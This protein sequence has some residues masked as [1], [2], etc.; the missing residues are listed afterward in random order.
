LTADPALGGEAEHETDGID[1][2][3]RV[4]II[5]VGPGDA[6]TAVALAAQN[7]GLDTY[8]VGRMAA[9]TDDGSLAGRLGLSDESSVAYLENLTDDTGPLSDGV[10]AAALPA[11]QVRAPAA[12]PYHFYGAK[13]RN[14][15]IECLASPYGVVSTSPAGRHAQPALVAAVDAG[16]LSARLRDC[17]VDADDDEVL[18]Q[19]VFSAGRVVG[20]VLE[21]S[22]GSRWVAATRAVVIATGAGAPLPVLPAGVSG[23]LALVTHPESRF[24]RLELVLK[25]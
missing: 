12:P 8:L 17:A 3:D 18:G 22:A 7:A 6:A 23:D 21:S 19:L 2:D 13:L 16:D 9:R 20:A 14:W 24:A 25:Q 11:H 4:D 5:C 15:A 1:W 10:D